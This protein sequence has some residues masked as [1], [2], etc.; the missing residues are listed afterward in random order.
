ME[1]PQPSKLSTGKNGGMTPKSRSSLRSW[2]HFTLCGRRPDI[3][4]PASEFLEKLRPSYWFSAHLHCKFAALVQHGEGS[5][6]TKFLALD[7]CLPGRKFLQ[8]IEVE[9]EPGPYEL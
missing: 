8:V 2:T 1:G 9:S 5:S 7:K 6:V 4:L 3:G